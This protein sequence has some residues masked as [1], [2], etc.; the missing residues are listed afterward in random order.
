MLAVS[1]AQP[2]SGSGACLIENPV[3][4]SRL[5]EAGRAVALPDGP[6]VACRFALSFAAWAGRSAA[7]VLSA[8]RGAALAA[9]QTGPGWECRGRNRQ[10]GAKMSAH[11]NGLAL[12]VAG[13]TFADGSRLAVSGANDPGVQAVRTSACEWF[14][15]VL[16]PGS[17]VFHSDHLHLDLQPHGRGGRYRMC[18]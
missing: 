14:T 4:L 6:I 7:P 15:T 17:D 2:R 5:S 3:R 13:F 10:P 18:Q 1:V 8:R 9:I 12:D 16:G 11:A